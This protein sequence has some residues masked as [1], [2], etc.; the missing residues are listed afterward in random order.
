MATA[1][2]LYERRLAQEISERKQA[3]SLFEKKKRE[4]LNLAAQD[5]QPAEIDLRENEERYQLL[6]ELSPDAI[7]IEI[8]GR[9][10]YANTAAVRLFRAQDPSELLGYQMRPPGLAPLSTRCGDGLQPQARWHLQ[11]C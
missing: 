1:F 4:L 11:C 8:E 6:V 2:E 9:L 10:I 3:E 5:R 7:S